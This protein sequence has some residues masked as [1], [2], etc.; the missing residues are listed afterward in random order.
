MGICKFYFSRL[1]N[2]FI[3]ETTV[4]T[5]KEIERMFENKQNPKISKVIY[6]RLFLDCI[7]FAENTYESTMS[8]RV[9]LTK[10]LYEN[11]YL[12]SE[13]D[14][15]DMEDL[16]LISHTILLIFRSLPELKAEDQRMRKTLVYDLIEHMFI[17]NIGFTEQLYE[18]LDYALA[19]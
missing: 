9:K 11:N 17:L 14:E 6:F 13:K 12:L 5:G 16:E 7:S 19:H 8:D 18:C 4:M 3:E 10:L 15:K 2:S 1:S